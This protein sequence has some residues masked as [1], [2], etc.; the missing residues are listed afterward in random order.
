MERLDWFIGDREG[1]DRGFHVGLIEVGRE[2]GDWGDDW[3]DCWWM[4]EVS[5]VTS[6]DGGIGRD[7]DRRDGWW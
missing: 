5:R 1:W 7:C 4:R 2:R 6:W 3:W